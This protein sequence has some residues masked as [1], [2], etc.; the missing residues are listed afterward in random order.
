MSTDHGVVGTDG[1]YPIQD[2][3]PL[4]RMWSIDQLWRGEAGLNKYVPKVKDWATDPDTGEIWVVDHVDP[5][6]LIPTLRPLNLAAVGTF[7]ENERLIGMGPGA[8][9]D[10]FRI[11]LNDA[12]FPHTLSVDTG[13][14]IKG[15]MSS[16]AKIFLGT[17]TSD[18]TGHVVSK[19]YDNSGNF[20]STSIPLEL[21][22]IDSHTNYAI[23]AVRRCNCTER[24]VNGEL[25]TLVIYADDGHV[26][27]KRQMMIENTD[28]I[29]D[30]HVGLKYITE[31][32]LESIWLSDSDVDTIEYP[33][34]LPLN[35]LNMIGVV[36]YSDGSE[37]KYPVNGGKFTMYGL[38]GKVSTIPY[39][40]YPL[41]LRYLISEGET[42]YASTGENNKYI[43]KP[44]ALVT[45]NPNNSIQVKL[46]AYPEWQGPEIGYTIRWFLM[47]MERNIRF[48]V[49]PHVHFA[50]NTGPFDPTLYGYIQ[51]K[52][53]TVNLRDV[54]PSFIPF[55]HTQVVD[56]V[57]RNP[58]SADNQASWTVLNES[59]VSE[60]HYGHKVYGFITDDGKVNFTA[61]NEDVFEWLTSYYKTTLPLTD[62]TNET[63]APEPT[64]FVVTYAG[65]EATFP[66][67]HWNQDLDIGIGL[68]S[69]KLVTIRFIKRTPTADLQLSWAGAILKRF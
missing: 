55:I 30:T 56:I 31:I 3:E 49:T 41:A 6:T 14:G 42:A 25:M 40:R 52:A 66:I 16:Y 9:S 63:A 15:T 48:E 20:I 19:V 54:S 64:H 32:S 24:F 46:F 47:N 8:P 34:N 65:Q 4:W 38:S 43:T 27:Y 7:T 61:G 39:Q 67:S 62:L 11:Y 23:K 68:V 13:C 57:L 22:A 36:H 53:V 21:I 12:V 45:I 58:P 10:V 60:T 28:T 69:G 44:F 37:V 29:A 59:G 1:R 17:D 5:N 18:E 51:R 50:N 2:D 26:V 35:S 33:L